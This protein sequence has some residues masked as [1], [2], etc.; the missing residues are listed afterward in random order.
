MSA[1]SDGIDLAAEAAGLPGVTASSVETT[2]ECIV[3]QLVAPG[4]TPAIDYRHLLLA[5]IGVGTPLTVLL[6]DELTNLSA[7]LDAPR[8]AH[9]RS[10]YVAPGSDI[11]AFVC[12]TVAEAVELKQVGVE[13]DLFDLA[14]DSLV[15]IE[16][17]TAVTE[18]YGVQLD[19]QDVFEAGT[20][21]RIAALVTAGAPS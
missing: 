1:P 4:T 6:V 7:A 12:A 14:A 13:D 16:L 5:T 19:V 20:V 11:E 15:L 18:R 8:P 21:G 17:T 10:T 9:R 3:V 2:P